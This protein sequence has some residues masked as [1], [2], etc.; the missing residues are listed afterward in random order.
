MIDRWIT[1]VQ[2]RAPCSNDCVVAPELIKRVERFRDI[3][4]SVNSVN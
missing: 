2:G 4:I 3:Y 1:D